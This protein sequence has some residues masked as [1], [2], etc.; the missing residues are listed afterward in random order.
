MIS[1]DLLREWKQ[2]D[3]K[4]LEHAPVWVKELYEAEIKPNMKEKEKPA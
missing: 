4:T 1:E 2:I 3:A